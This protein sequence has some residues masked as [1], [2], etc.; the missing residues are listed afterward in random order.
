MGTPHAPGCR[1]G[2]NRPRR[3]QLLA[4][5]D[6][7]PDDRSKGNTRYWRGSARTGRLL[8]HRRQGRIRQMGAGHGPHRSPHS[9][10][11]ADRPPGRRHPEGYMG[12]RRGLYRRLRFP[13]HYADRL[14]PHHP[15]RDHDRSRFEA[16]A[17]ACSHSTFVAKSRPLVGV[18][19]RLR[20]HRGHRRA[21]HAPAPG[22]GGPGRDRR[23]N[24]LQLRHIRPGGDDRDG[25]SGQPLRRP[26]RTLRPAHPRPPGSRRRAG[27]ARYLHQLR[28]DCRRHGRLR[29]RIRPGIPAATAMVIGATGSDRRGMAFE[30]STPSTRSAWS[31]ERPAAVGWPSSGTIPSAFPSSQ[32]QQ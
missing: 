20:H 26:V 32:R 19:R 12:R 23:A 17:P 9:G 14:P 11:G 18:R 1:D 22:V 3:P 6:P 8:D 13:P 15:R 28:G 7:C 5:P 16:C 25:Q 21:R 2:D 24:G 29:P 27:S 31:W 4:G 10:C 30:S